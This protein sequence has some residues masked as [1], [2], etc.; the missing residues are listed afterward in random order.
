MFP[1]NPISKDVPKPILL[2]VLKHHRMALRSLIQDAVAR[3]V[4]FLPVLQEKLL[5]LG[6]NLMDL[7]LGELTVSQLSEAVLSKL[8]SQRTLEYQSFVSW[9][10]A[11]SG[12]QILTLPHDQSCWV[13]RASDDKERYI[14]IHP[15]R[16]SPATSRVR[17]QALK[18]AVMTVVASQLFHQDRYDIK[19]VNRVRVEYLNFSP[20]R[21][22]SP[23]NGVGKLMGYLTAP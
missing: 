10:Q 22:V 18:T 19:L 5:V 8:S 15:G 3:G 23:N 14:H 1:L 4:D 7:Y 21:S 2:N 9:V 11:E 13:L 12:Y 6:E 17:A 20:M 16:W